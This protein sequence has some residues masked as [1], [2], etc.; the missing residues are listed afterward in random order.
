[1]ERNF[2]N[3]DDMGWNWHKSWIIPNLCVKLEVHKKHNINTTQTSLTP[4]LLF[5]N[6]KIIDPQTNEIFNPPKNTFA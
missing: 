1:M 6:K 4:P 2:I 3:D 5:L